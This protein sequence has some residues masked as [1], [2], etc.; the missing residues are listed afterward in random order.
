MINIV[1]ILVVIYIAS[2]TA[3]ITEQIEKFNAVL[4]EEDTKLMQM[5]QKCSDPIFSEVSVPES[6]ESGASGLNLR[7]IARH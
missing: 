7:Y 4:N 5:V 1:T 6:I 3:D 2:E